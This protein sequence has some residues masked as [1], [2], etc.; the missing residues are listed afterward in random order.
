MYKII[1]NALKI[2]ILLISVNCFAEFAPVNSN[3]MVGD[4]AL[5]SITHKKRSYEPVYGAPQTGAFFMIRFFQKI[6]SPQSGPSCKFS[7]TCSAYG[8]QAVQ[9]HGA[10]WGSLLS[11]ERILR[12]NPFTHAGE[13]KIPQK[14]FGQ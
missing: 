6:L 9:K 5:K 8:R 14:L 10:F 11:G 12:C 1:K 2:I 7:P 4:E 13:D 3:V